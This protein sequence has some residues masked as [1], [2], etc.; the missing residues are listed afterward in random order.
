VAGV[1]ATAVLSESYA[2]LADEPARWGWSW[3][4]EPDYFG[5]ATMASVMRRLVGDPR[6]DAVGRFDVG[7]VLVDG[8]SDTSGYALTTLKGDMT[9]T[10]RRGRLPATPGEVALGEATLTR[11][12]THI[13]GRVNVARRGSTR[14]EALTVVGTVVFPP[15]ETRVVDT[16]A[17]F[18]PAGLV[19]HVQDDPTQSIVLRYPAHNDVRT[20][21]TGLARDYGLDFNPFTE[22]QVPG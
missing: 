19:A 9:L 5:K 1:A 7:S 2:R 21:E 22:P 14:T 15:S 17:A 20:I 10:L 11:A 18:T 3:S 12:K 16:G 13:G 4:S 8:S 6:V